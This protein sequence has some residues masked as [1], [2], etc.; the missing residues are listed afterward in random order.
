M[1]RPTRYTRTDTP[2]PYTTRYRIRPAP[3]RG[4]AAHGALLLRSP[5]WAARRR[6]D[7]LAA[8]APLSQARGRRLPA[9]PQG[10]RLPGRPR[11]RRRRGG[12]R[13]APLRTLLSRLERAPPAPRGRP[14]GGAGRPP[15]PSEVAASRPYPP[16]CRSPRAGH[17]RAAAALP[18]LGR[19]ATSRG[20]N[21]HLNREALQSPLRHRHDP[22]AEE[23]YRQ[24]KP[25][26]TKRNQ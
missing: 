26:T 22:P 7:R 21:A 9:R 17:A 23:L 5:R 16:Q 4:R 13:A 2:C 15:P 18:T 12:G 25:D 14:W 11:H 20:Q 10:P 24:H 19:G 3:A 6:A 8:A 1:R